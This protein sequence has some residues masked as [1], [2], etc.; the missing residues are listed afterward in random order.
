MPSGLYA[1][2]FIP[3]VIAGVFAGIFLVTG[4]N[5]DP[6]SLVINAL[7]PVM[8]QFG[9][10]A[11]SIWNLSTTILLLASIVAAVITIVTIVLTGLPGIVVGI[12]GFLGMILIITGQLAVVGVFMLIIGLVISIVF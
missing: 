3:A 9:G 8:H 2:V 12:C 11:S 4:I 7:N 6:D 10:T 1:I 5:I